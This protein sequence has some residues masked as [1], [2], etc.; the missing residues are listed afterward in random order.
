MTMIFLSILL[1]DS[2]NIPLMIGL[3][4]VLGLAMGFLLAFLF[5]WIIQTLNLAKDGLFVLFI[6]ATSV[7]VYSLTAV[8]NGNAYL[9]VY[10]YGIFIGNKT[11]KGKRETVFFYDGLGNLMQI[12]LFF[13]LGLLS[14][15]ASF[16]EHLPLAA[17][18]MLFMF[19]IARPLA[20]YLLAIP[21]GLKNIQKILI[22]VAGLRGAAAI[23]FA[24]MATNTGVDIGADIYNTVFGICVLS[25]AVQ[26]FLMP[27][28][29]KKLAMLD[30]SDTVLRTF[31]DY[32]DRSDLSFIQ[33]VISEDSR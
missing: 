14:D 4:V 25:S 7:L 28:A 23:A 19:I 17:A 16:I 18:I 12:G 11:F 2:T 22:S 33:T 26:G 30:P 15:W 8:L 31:N 13:M 1:G 3:Q 21:F 20:V 27:I 9:A 5:Y 32:Q 29:S 6:V 24:I 10:I